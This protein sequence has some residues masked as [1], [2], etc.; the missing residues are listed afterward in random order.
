MLLVVLKEGHQG[1]AGV[2]GPIGDL[3]GREVVCKADR[4][5][6]REVDRQVLDR[7]ELLV[8]REL[9]EAPESLRRTN[10]SYLDIA[11]NLVI[12]SQDHNRRTVRSLINVLVDVLDCLYGGTDLHVNMRAELLKEVRVIRNHPA[13]ITD[14]LLAGEA[15]F[16]DRKR[17]AIV[18]ATVLGIPV[19]VD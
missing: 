13:V 4:M 7:G 5:L 8:R 2:C 16:A 19:L 9:E 1:R 10:V 17:A 12:R 15:W 18:A 11:G 14:D 6:P 3:V